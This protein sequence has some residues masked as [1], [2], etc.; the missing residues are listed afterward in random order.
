MPDARY[1]GPMHWS[2]SLSRAADTAVA[3]SEALSGLS[4]PAAPPLVLVF[5][6][7]HHA[8]GWAPM[9]HA[10]REAHP[11]AR[12]VGCSTGG[13]IGSGEEVEGAPGL[14]LLAGVLPDVAI[15]PFHLPA[16]RVSRADPIATEDLAESLGIDPDLRPSFLLFLD[17]FSADADIVL[18]ALDD[19]FVGATKAG[20]LASG[21][22]RAGT[23][24]LFVD[25]TVHHHGLVGVALWGD[26]QLDVVVAQ[27]CRPVGPPQ[28]VAESHAHV[29]AA[30]EEA[31]A[32]DVLQ[33]VFQDLDA[34]SRRRFQASPMVGVAMNPAGSTTRQGDYLIRHVVGVD[35]DRKAVAVAHVVSQGDVLRFHVRDPDASRDDLDELL[36]RD[37]RL[38]PGD[39]A[40][41]ALL[42]SC[43]GR[44][45]GF[46][47]VPDHDSKR[48]REIVGDVPMAG[49]FCNGE[50]GPIHGTTWLH[51]YTSVVVL[52]RRPDWN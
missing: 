18:P 25:D 2:S 46:Y 34:G 21:G 31:P 20:G 52:F 22:S 27:G 12:V 17:P 42:L 6:S 4:L 11:G 47:G 50:L 13:T 7:I 19:F 41:G 38:H 35:P 44:G 30:F 37:V 16:E 9:L 8:E 48:L 28:V 40:Q 43:L 49:F 26:V 36:H 5:A 3:T 15:E 23:N 10:I 32:F 39:P 45:E 14:S 51:S 1:G 33:A 29:V 24:G